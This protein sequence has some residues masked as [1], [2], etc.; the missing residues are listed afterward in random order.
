LQK[1]CIFYNKSEKAHGFSDRCIP[2]KLNVS[3]S[4]DSPFPSYNLLF[5]L[6]FYHIR[7][8]LRHKKMDDDY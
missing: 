7:L 8:E 3:N 1:V 4:H 6:I 5:V 2:E